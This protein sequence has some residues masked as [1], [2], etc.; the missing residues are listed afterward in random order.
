MKHNK[1]ALHVFKDFD[2]QALL[3]ETLFD[4][5]AVAVQYSAAYLKW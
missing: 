4:L 5:Y 1:T 2:I 3:C